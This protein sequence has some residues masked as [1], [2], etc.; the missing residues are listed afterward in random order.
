MAVTKIVDAPVGRVWA[1]FTD[2]AGRPSWLSEVESVE[3]LTPG[4]VRE[5]TTWRETR[6]GVEGE[7]V[8]EQLVVTALEPE[9]ACTIELAPPTTGGGQLTYLFAPIDVGPHRGGTTVTAAPAG[10]PHGLRGR[11][12]AFVMGGFAAQTAEGALRDELDALADA[13]VDQPAGNGTPGPDG[14][15]PVA[16]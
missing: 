8:T 12:L 1:V 5:S 13:C 7:L 9:R 4:P 11:L 6:L 3:V 15:R 14:D 16:A 10:R 2:L